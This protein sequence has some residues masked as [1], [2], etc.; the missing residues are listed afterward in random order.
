MADTNDLLRDVA[1]YI[2][3]VAA[4]AAN[5]QP[6][7]RMICWTFERIGGHERVIQFRKYPEGDDH[8][9]VALPAESGVAE[10]IATWD[11]RAAEAVATLLDV[12]ADP[13]VGAPSA[14]HQYALRLA[15]LLDE[16][17]S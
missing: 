10:H 9:I 6:D 12:I 5:D 11:P 7:D 3:T 14:V 2:R 1:E 17:R 16:G 8:E 13:A 4:T 15:E